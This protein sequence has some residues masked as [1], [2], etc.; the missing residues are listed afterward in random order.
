MIIK[1]LFVN[2]F[3]IL[4]PLLTMKKGDFVA[5]L[6]SNQTGV[7]GKILSD[8]KVE[9]ILDN[10]F[11]VQVNTDKLEKSTPPE[12]NKSIPKKHSIAMPPYRVDLHIENLLND[13]SYLSNGEKIRLQLEVFEKSLSAAIA[14]GMFEITFVHGVGQGV[15]R[16]QIHAI[17]KKTKEIK[18]FAD[19][20]FDRGATVVKIY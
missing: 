11:T 12:K 14:S 19:A 5:L 9:L 18:S 4:I 6:D 20:Q 10:G 2:S 7:I 8:K 3:K 13:H 17:L 15:L 16:K 1:L